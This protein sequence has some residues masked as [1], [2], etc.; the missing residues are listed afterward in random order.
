MCVTR[1]LFNN[2]LCDISRLGTGMLSTECHSSLM[3]Y[4]AAS[5]CLH[6]IESVASASRRAFDPQ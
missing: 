4:T 1:H 6:C 5:F 3:F 2:S